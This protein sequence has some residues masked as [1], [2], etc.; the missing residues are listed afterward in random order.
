MHRQRCIGDIV[1]YM[2]FD[3]GVKDTFVI[4]NARIN[5]GLRWMYLF[6]LEAIDGSGERLSVTNEYMAPIYLPITPAGSSVKAIYVPNIDDDWTEEKREKMA[7]ETRTLLI[8]SFVHIDNLWQMV[9]QGGDDPEHIAWAMTCKWVEEG[10][11]KQK[12]RRRNPMNMS[13]LKI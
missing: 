12:K 13:G 11:K 4:V 5:P 6:T 2:D 10:L 8:F 3:A 7:E 9:E 1:Q